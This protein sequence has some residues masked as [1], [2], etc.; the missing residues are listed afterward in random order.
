VTADDVNSYIK[1][2]TDE[3]FSAKDF[4]TWSG[5]VL[6]A[7]ALAST[8]PPDSRR[9]RDR[10]VKSA[11]DKVADELGNTPAVA[12]GSY[13]DPRLFDLYRS[14]QPIATSGR[15]SGRGSLKGLSSAERRV[16]ELL[17]A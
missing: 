1:E 16:R 13:I 8:D 7:V 5:T 12:R 17:G 10:V 2:N 11:V 3:R 4:R 6:A 15:L 9:G 14:G